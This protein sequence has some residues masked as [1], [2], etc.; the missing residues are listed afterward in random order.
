[1]ER[2]WNRKLGDDD[3]AFGINWFDAVSYCRWLTAQVINSQTTQCYDN[4]A[5]LHKD[6]QGNPQ[7]DR[8]YLER[9]GFR[10]PTEAEWEAACRSGTQTAYSF[11]NDVQRLGRYAWFQD[12]LNKW[13]HHAGALRPNLRGLCDIHGNLVEWT[14]DRYGDYAAVASTDPVGMKE[15][16]FRVLWGGSWGYAAG[17]CWS[18]IRSVSDPW[19][20]GN[21]LGFRAAWSPSGVTPEA[22][23]GVGASFRSGTTAG[24]R[25]QRDARYR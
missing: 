15:G 21:Y 18:A 24:T 14:H 13:S 2:Q 10:L 5:T 25:S 11:G 19:S 23:S 4:P 7:Y 22:D 6:S 16:S 9:G 8:V 12:T 1:M 20:R 3:P 17:G